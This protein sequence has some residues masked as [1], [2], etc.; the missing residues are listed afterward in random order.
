MNRRRRSVREGR[1]VGFEVLTAVGMKSSLF[2]DITPCSPKN[3]TLQRQGYP[4]NS[5]IKHCAM[6]TYGA[7]EV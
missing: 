6:K 5:L 3:R 2:R 4:F 1:V 7:V